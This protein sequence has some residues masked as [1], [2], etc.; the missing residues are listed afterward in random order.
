MITIYFDGFCSKNPGGIATYGVV[1][2]KDDVV[3]RKALDII[4]EGPNMTNNVA[5]FY[6]L[7]KALE[8][9]TEKGL[10]DEDIKIKGDSQ[11]VIHQLIGSWNVKSRTSKIYVPLILYL[12]EDKKVT[13]Q[14]IP[15][16]ENSAADELAYKAYTNHKEAMQKLKN[17]KK[18]E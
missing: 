1:I 12:L 8:W 11:L 7:W 14:W 9:L 18:E 10:I 16:E 5:E 13:F 6:G 15:R 2:Y 3:I 4:G 17:T